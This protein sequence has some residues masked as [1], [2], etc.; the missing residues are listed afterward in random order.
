MKKKQTVRRNICKPINCC[1]RCNLRCRHRVGRTVDPPK[2]FPVQ[3]SLTARRRHGLRDHF[4][5]HLFSSKQTSIQ[6]KCVFVSMVSS[7]PTGRFVTAWLLFNS[8]KIS[9]EDDDDDVLKISLLSVGVW[10]SI[11][12]IAL[13][14]FEV[15]RAAPRE[16]CSSYVNVSDGRFGFRKLIRVV[17]A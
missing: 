7:K 8:K 11:C 2:N 13:K 9:T 16:R 17:L 15:F 5:E 14:S 12:L 4:S 3:W 10:Y 1:N 6:L